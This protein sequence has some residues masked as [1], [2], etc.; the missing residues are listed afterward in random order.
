M[1]GSSDPSCAVETD[2]SAP[3]D[4]TIPSI[5]V[6]I[7]APVESLPEEFCRFVE[8]HCARA[9]EDVGA[10]PGCIQLIAL[11]TDEEYG[12]TIKRLDPEATYSD[13]TVVAGIGKTICRTDE[14]GEVRCS[15]VLRLYPVCALW[16][17]L[18][19]KPER[20]GWDPTLHIAEYALHH[21]VAHC[22]DDS[23]RGCSKPIPIRRSGAGFEIS[24]V[25]RYHADILQSE[26]A[27]CVLSAKA[28][29]PAGHREEIAMFR[30]ITAD[31]RQRAAAERQRY[32]NTG[33]H[34][35]NVAFEAAGCFW[36]MLIQ[37]AKIAATRLGN[38]TLDVEEPLLMGDSR[39]AAFNMV[40]ADFEPRLAEHWKT[41]PNWTAETP[42]F[43]RHAWEELARADNYHFHEDA[44][45]SALFFKPR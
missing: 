38:P 10:P 14:S 41:Y 32:W 45:G 40:L 1:F 4:S 16:I 26:F 3:P 33:Q 30:Q 29:A 44:R 5:T 2:H 7:I 13:N 17:E 36:L 39:A 20:E 28:M 9:I 25:A 21:E 18:N 19:N 22:V 35:A 11:T 12:P 23:K 15:I 42:P 27:A 8:D 24:Q 34:L 43:M 31:S 6:A 37:F